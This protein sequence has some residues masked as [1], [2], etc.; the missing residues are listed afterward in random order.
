MSVRSRR[1]DARFGAVTQADRLK[2]MAEIRTTEGRF[3]SPDELN[4]LVESEREEQFETLEDQRG[5]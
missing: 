5:R 1:V 2:A 3:M 4:R